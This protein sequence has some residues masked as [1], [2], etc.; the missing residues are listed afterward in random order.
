[1]SRSSD[2]TTLVDSRRTSDDQGIL[3]AT[4]ES[5]GTE[6]IVID[7]QLK[8]VI[9]AIGRLKTALPR[10]IYKIVFATS[11][12][13]SDET[14]VLFPGETVTVTANPFNLRF[15]TAAPLH[16]TTNS[17]EYHRAAAAQI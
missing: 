3:V 10:G 11:G 12:A 9:K 5:P 15:P 8:R 6:I 16:G 17:R 13:A 1:M 4:A 7:G 2:G 14:I